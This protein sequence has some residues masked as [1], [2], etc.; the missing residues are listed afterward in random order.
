[1]RVNGYKLVSGEDEVSHPTP[2]HD[3]LHRKGGGQ[4]G[5][6]WESMQRY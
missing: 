5:D 1:M 6:G 3:Q 2:D 4:S